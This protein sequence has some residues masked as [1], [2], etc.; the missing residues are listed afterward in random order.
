MIEKQIELEILYADFKRNLAAHQ[1]KPHAE[2][3]Q[4][5]LARV[6]Q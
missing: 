3:D 1:A 6:F 4:E 2:F 5:E